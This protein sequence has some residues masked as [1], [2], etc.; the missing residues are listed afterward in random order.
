MEDY[1]AETGLVLLE[2]KVTVTVVLARGDLLI[3]G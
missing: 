1:S 3:I 2:P